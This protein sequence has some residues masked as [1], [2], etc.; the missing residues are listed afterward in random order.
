MSRCFSPVRLAPLAL[1]WLAGA[2][3]AQDV[4][5]WSARV[6]PSPVRPGEVAQ[7]ILTAEMQDG[8]HVYG[9]NLPAGGPRPTQFIA[10]AADSAEA[11]GGLREPEPIEHH[12]EAFAMDVLWHEGTAEFVQPFRVADDAAG[13]ITLGGTIEFMACNDTSCLPPKKVPLS[14]TVEV[15]AGAVR[16]EWAEPPAETDYRIA[17][18][19]AGP[20]PTTDPAPTEAPTGD[21]A[22]QGSA[23]DAARSQGL[24]AFLLVAFL[25]GLAALLTPCVFPMIP[26]T[27]SFFTKQ[28]EGNPGRR[29]GLAAA[30][31]GGIIVMYTG[32]GL[33]LAALMGPGG[34]QR[35][36]ANP[37]MN[38]A[39]AAIF[40]FFALTLFG[41]Y[42][43][44]LPSGLLTKTQR[45]GDA[46]GYLGALFMGLALTL[47]AFTCTVQFVGG[48]LVWAA[49]G[50]WLWPILGMLSFSLAF[51]LPF[52]LLALFPQYLAALPKA[53]GWMEA[54]K[55]T[56]GFIELGAAF[57][58]LSN[59]DLVWNWQLLTRE[60]V[61]SLWSLLAAL[62]A[63]YLWGKL[64]VN[65]AT[66]PERPGR[67]RVV[68]GWLF[69]LLAAWFAWGLTGAR[70]SA[71]L[72]AIL[73]PPHY[74]R[75]LKA[76]A[77]TNNHADWL[78]DYDE[79]LQVARQTGTNVFVDFTGV[80][81]TNC[82]W[83][84]QN[85][86]ILPEV[87][88][89]LEQYTKVQLYTDSGAQAQEHQQL[90]TDRYGTASLP[91]YALLTPEGETIA[92]FDGLT[93]DPDAFAAFLAQGL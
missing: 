81:C 87:T 31:G 21:D 80:T 61:L 53:G 55:V 23:A 39:F 41:Y 82:R 79:A 65:H 78:R 56:L 5:Q 35:L 74:G 83:M 44:E 6:E 13:T 27:V 51:A 76:S 46:G 62:T 66:Q 42:E 3:A 75:G 90:Q 60:M 68:W 45:L 85:I 43:L 4:V 69:A 58:F 59:A 47:A 32:L 14:A 10:D 73:P 25:A 12:D 16:P 9:L 86:F 36:A 52:F 40:V 54:V 50:E 71:L 11:L 93:R 8:W 72:E 22:F 70:T 48:V 24:L 89:K 57:K 33:L 28:A 20:T 49:N 67:G 15:A 34:A 37:W 29:V 17:G 63:A 19:G 91:F 1:L 64:R 88:D 26:I 30:Y 38:L 18:A 7:L 84:E 92:T 77:A 2:A